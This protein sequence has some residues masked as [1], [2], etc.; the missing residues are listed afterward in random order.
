MRPPVTYQGGKVRLADQIVEIIGLP[1]RERFFDL[2]CG[3]GAVSVAAVN[4]G[5]KPSRITMV[6]FSPWGRFWKAIGDGAFDLDTFHALVAR[7]PSDVRKIKAFITALY[8]RPVGDDA[9]YVFLLLQAATVGGAAVW[10]E[11][12]Q[13]K[14]GGGFRDYWTPTATSSRRSPVNP[15]MPMPATIVERV[16]VLAERMRGV[17]GICADLASVVPTVREGRA[18]I[19]PPYQGTTAY[20]HR[21]DVVAIARSLRVPCWVSEG[22]ALTDAAVC[23]S[24]GRVKG[25]ITGNRK[26]APNEEWLSPF[27]PRKR[28]KPEDTK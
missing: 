12:R 5:Q 25:G 28:V 10:I 24:R 16:T 3:S 11:G 14:K 20:G 6:D 4:A 21:L 15:M 23:L 26:R 7:L 2:C 22:R 1:L 18:Y 9:V 17:T 27:K 19:D 8:E 13:W